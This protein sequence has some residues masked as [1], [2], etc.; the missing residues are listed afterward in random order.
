MRKIFSISNI[1]SVLVQKAKELQIYQYVDYKVIP[2]EK[3]MGKQHDRQFIEEKTQEATRTHIS[4]D[5]DYHQHAERYKV[6]QTMSCHF[7]HIR[8]HNKLGNG[9]GQEHEAEGLTHCWWVGT[10]IMY[11][12]H[13]IICG[14]NLLLISEKMDN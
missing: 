6:K 4:K 13:I 2:M 12:Y 3:I 11:V 1:T 8:K 14:S 5:T 10:S 7:K 9:Q